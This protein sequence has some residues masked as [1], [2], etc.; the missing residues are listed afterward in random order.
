MVHT[1]I[2]TFLYNSLL[3]VFS[4]YIKI[5]IIIIIII[6]IKKYLHLDNKN[7][8]KNITTVKIYELKRFLKSLFLKTL[9]LSVSLICFNKLL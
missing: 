3:E 4:P 7:R 1:H 6:I 8:K 2:H 9:R 5:I